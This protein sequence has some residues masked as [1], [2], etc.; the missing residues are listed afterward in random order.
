MQLVHARW[1]MDLWSSCQ[2]SLARGWGLY[3]VL[4]TYNQTAQAGTA[5]QSEPS[6]SL[7]T[8]RKP[9]WPDAKNTRS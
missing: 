5:T 3:G 8:L 2:G 1:R 6:I 9:G 4:P 7:G